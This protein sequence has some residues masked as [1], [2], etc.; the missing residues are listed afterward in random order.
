MGV[1]IAIIVFGVSGS[2]VILTI[3]TKH[4]P[5]LVDKDY[6]EQGRKFEST[7]LQQMEARKALG[8]NMQLLIPSTLV[9][10]TITYLIGPAATY[11]F[12]LKDSNSQPLQGAKV[13]LFAYRPSDSRADFRVAMHEVAAG[14]YQGSLS[15]PLQGAWTLTAQARLGKDVSEVVRNVYVLPVQ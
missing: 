1:L 13:T 14:R 8:W 15:F 4:K 9:G 5:N 10:E 6:Y 3:T 12:A 2:M 7:I 11:Q